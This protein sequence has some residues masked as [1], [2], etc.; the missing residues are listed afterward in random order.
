DIVKLD[1]SLVERSTWSPEDRRIMHHLVSMLH[2]AG[3]MVLAE[4][5]E[6]D[7]ALQAL[8]DADIDFVQGFQFGQPD[9]SI[10][11][12][13]AAVPAMLDAAWQR[14][15]AR[16]HAPPAPAQPGFDAIE[17]LVL[18]GAAAFAASGDLHDAAQ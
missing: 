13:S 18:A 2:Q 10:A 4:G 15:I 5:V 3:A 8:M 6:S 1:R 11:H 14:F 7:D 16:R 9:T 12:A 17:R